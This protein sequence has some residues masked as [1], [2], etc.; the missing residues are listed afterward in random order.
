MT[1]EPTPDVITEEDEPIEDGT[2]PDEPTPE[3]EPE[4]VPEG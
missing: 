4:A 3:D 2:L 1:D